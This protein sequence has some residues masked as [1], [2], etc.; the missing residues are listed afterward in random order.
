MLFKIFFGGDLFKKHTFKKN[1]FYFLAV[2][3][4]FSLYRVNFMGYSA[5]KILMIEKEAE[6]GGLNCS[7]N[8]TVSK[9]GEPN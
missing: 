7:S 6:Q 9:Q 8:R 2:I 1:K 5:N 3:S 4:W